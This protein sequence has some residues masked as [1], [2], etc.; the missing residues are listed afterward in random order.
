MLAQEAM[1]Q[2]K[3]AVHLVLE[4]APHGIRN[5]EVGRLLGIHAGHVGHEGHIPRTL[6]ALME[7]EGVVTQDPSTKLWRLRRLEDL[8][9]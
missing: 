4:E 7:S 1:A 6:L 9:E 8:R 5:A 3:S 2:L